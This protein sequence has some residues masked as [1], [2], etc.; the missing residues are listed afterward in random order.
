MTEEREQDLDH[1]T[2]VTNSSKSGTISFNSF[3]FVRI[4]F[5]TVLPS[6]ELVKGK[7]VENVEGGCCVS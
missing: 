7:M 6:L 1:K 5:V 4:L 2:R 3:G